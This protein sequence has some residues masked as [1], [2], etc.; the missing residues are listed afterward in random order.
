MEMGF[1]FMKMSVFCALAKP[2][3][4]IFSFFM[5]FVEKQESSVK[6]FFFYLRNSK[7]MANKSNIVLGLI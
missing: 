3:Q 5:V 7:R 6:V 2:L 1:K 4:S